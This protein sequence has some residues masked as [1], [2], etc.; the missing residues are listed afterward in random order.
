MGFTLVELLAA[1]AVGAL[2]LAGLSG[3]IAQ[4]LRTWEVAGE[5]REL[6]QEARFALDRMIEAAGGTTRLL[7]PRADDP[8]TGQTESVR[9]VLALALD[10]TL[11]RDRDGFADADNDRDGLVDEDPGRDATNDGKPGILGI[12]DDGDG[13]IDEGSR[14]NDDEDGRSD[15][16]EVNGLD[17]DGDGAVDEDADADLNDD[18]EPGVGGVDDDGDGYIDEGADDDDDEDAS[19]DEDWLDPVVFYLQG[20]SLIE[21]VP[22]PHPADGTDFRETVLSENVSDFRVERLSPAPEDR[23]LLVDILL[24]LTGPHGDTISLRSLARVGGAPGSRAGV[25]PP[26]VRPPPAAPDDL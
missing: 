15:E 26:A 4:G 17:D 2:L 10:P 24:E 18:R 21:R 19:E 1:L 8:G 22:V 3:A 5:R 11:D 23:A 7:L 12:D 6:T 9:A 13:R 14:R 16:D 20:T 25:L